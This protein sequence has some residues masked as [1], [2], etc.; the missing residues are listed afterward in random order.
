[1]YVLHRE[2]NDMN[3]ARNIMSGLSRLAVVAVMAL[4]AAC[5]TGG[6]D[7]PPPPASAASV[8]LTVAT[9]GGGTG[10]VTSNPAGLNCGAT[11]TLTVPSET[12]V[13]LTAAPAPN[14]TLTD[15]GG[16]CPAGSA[17]CAVTVNSNQTV[18]ATFNTSSAN[19]SLSVTFAGSGA[20]LITCNGGACNATYPWGASITV[21]GVANANSSFVG[22][23]GGGC[24]GTADC[25]VLLWADT[26]LTAT[27]NLL[28]VTA[29]LSVSKA[30]SGAGTVTSAP[31]GINCGATCS[32]NY[33]G[34]A[35]VT[36]TATPSGGSIFAGWTGGGCAGTGPCVVTLNADTTVTATFSTVP[37]TTV[38]TVITLGTGTGIVTCNGN[39]CASS[40]P[41]GTALTI[42]ATPGTSS[43][44]KGWLGACASA[45]TATTCNLVINAN[46]VVTVTFDLPKLSV[47]VAG[48]G[49]VTSVPA[50]IN[51]GSSCSASYS[52]GTVVTLTAT[53]ANFSGW[54]G[55][56]CSGT[57]TCIITLADDV[58]VT[59]TF[60]SV[61]GVGR[62]LFFA[63][64]GGPVLAVS[65]TSP[66]ATPITVTPAAADAALVYSGTWDATAKKFANLQ[67]AYLVYASNGKL[68][69]VNAATSSGSPGSG[70]NPSVQISSEAGA[71]TVCHTLVIDISPTPN[72]A[73]VAYELPGSDGQCSTGADNV[74]KIVSVSDS[75]VTPPSVLPTGLILS[76][77]DRA[78]YNL[79]TGT[80]THIYVT[81]AANSATAKIVNVSTKAVTTIQANVPGLT[82]LAQDTSDRVFV[83]NASNAPTHVLYVYTISTNS[84]VPLVT[85]S[86]SGVLFDGG[87]VSSDGTNLYISDGG[88]LFRVPLTATI[89]G[90]VGQMMSL[91][92]VITGVL[93]STNRVYVAQVD[94]GGS[95]L[96]SVAKTGGAPRVE[97][98]PALSSFV[99]PVSFSKNGLVYYTRLTTA[100][101]SPGSFVPLIAS[102]TA[103]I[104]REDGGVVSSQ[105]NA[106]FSQGIFE[107]TFG[108]RSESVV[109][110]S[111]F[112]LTSPGMS[113]SGGIL[114]AIDAATGT[115]SVTMGTIPSTWN[116]P[117][118]PSFPFFMFETLGS[119]AL[120]F[121]NSGDP[122]NFNNNSNLVFFV[123]AMVPNSLVQIP[124]AGSFWFP[125]L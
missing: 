116:I 65:S 12:V 8:T 17:T 70:T 89:P 99:L 14:N 31:A 69:R 74:I 30:G 59:A 121:S 101:P 119:S 55:G 87:L 1:M 57:S 84:L 82:I 21:A 34:G 78:V 28:P 97:V 94:A 9:A 27:F 64:Q 42:V 41:S 16:A 66:A 114:S 13:T 88:K 123:D 20:G 3:V 19:P 71:S 2:G 54:T 122:S 96:V 40:Y 100:P 107:P 51:C 58:T 56:G 124:V 112:L 125:V 102:A 93:P 120:G 76:N 110:S 118:L 105:S 85:G 6:G 38:L 91:S 25:T 44:F 18:T 113:F 49:T 33:A 115:Q 86:V 80:A 79:A 98:A 77:E 22:W 48:A 103:V 95:G 104:L 5:G 60:G 32:A 62:F 45:G 90:D 53:G 46:S 29:Q 73:R 43:L 67:G 36:L 63:Q 108:L 39:P 83:R 37:P 111:V 72:T 15:W 61:S 23:S 47:V 11:C 26:Q 106:W 7:T 109:P 50:G 75:N 24:T 35:V 68:W 81:D 117:I 10:T 92:G 4:L 52:K